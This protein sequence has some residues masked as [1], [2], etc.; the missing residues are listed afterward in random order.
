M[1]AVMLAST[2]L[3]ISTGWSAPTSSTRRKAATRCSGSTCSGSSAI[4]RSTSSSC[5][6]SASCRR[7]SPTFSRRPV[8]G[9]TAMVLVDR[10]DRLHRLRGV[11]APHVRDRPAAAR[12]ELLHRGEHHDRDPDRRPDLLL[13]RHALERPAAVAHA[14]AVRRSASSS[15]FVIGGLTGVMLASRAA[16]PA[17]PRH[18]LRRRAL[19]LRA[20]RRHRLPA[21][22]RPL[23]LVPEDH[24]PDAERAARQAGTSGCCSSAST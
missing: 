4:P 9:Y 11:G 5:R 8:F 12:P 1:P 15:I 17:G 14:A 18:L 3:L 19:P 21:A 23:L 2:L 24:R 7:S 13:D 10:R 6:R 20:D 22:R 16:R